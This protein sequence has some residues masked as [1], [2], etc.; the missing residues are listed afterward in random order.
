MPLGIDEVSIT[1]PPGQKV[2]GPFAVITGIV[3]GFTVTGVE[4]E[5][6]L[7]PLALVTVTL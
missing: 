1:L 6:V 3:N 5:A 4:P 7:Q 2:V